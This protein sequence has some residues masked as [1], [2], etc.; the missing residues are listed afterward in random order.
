M[1]N[2]TYFFEAIRHPEIPIGVNSHDITCLEPIVEKAFL[3]RGWVVA[4]A[5]GNPLAIT[6]SMR[7]HSYLHHDLRSTNP[8]LA[9]FSG[10][11]IFSGVGVNQA[12]FPGS[13]QSTVASPSELRVKVTHVPAKSFPTLPQLD[14]SSYS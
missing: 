9:F 1:Q 3:G 14:S 12:S 4:I 5:P 6:L 2:I 11:D 10:V 13:C 7:L 8:K